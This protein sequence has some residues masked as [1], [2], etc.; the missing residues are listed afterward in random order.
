MAGAG[1]TFSESWHRITDQKLSLRSTVEVRKQ[2]FRGERWYVLHDPFNNSFFRLRPEAHEFV[3]RLRPDRTVGDVWEE[4]LQRNPDSAP[5]QEHVI[6]LLAQ[7]YFANLLHYENPADSAKLFERYRERKQRELKS[8][9]LSIMFIRLPL[10]DPENLLKKIMPVIRSIVS[11]AGAVLWLITVLM[12]GKVFV[13]HF[14]EAAVQAQAILAPD[15]LIFL[16]VSLVLIKTLH[17][18]GHAFVCK[19]FGGEVHTMGIMLMVFTPLPYMDAT[20][21]WSFRSRRERILVSSAGMIFEILAA[22]IAAFI[23]V[24]TGPGMIH[25]LAYNMMF[26]AS[27]S[28]VLFNINPLLRFDGYYILSDL[29]DIPNLHSRSRMHLRHLAEYYLFGC[30]DS[31]SPAQTGREASW[32]TAFGV[33]SGIYR[34]VIFTAIILFVADRFLMAGLIMALICIISWGVAPFIRFAIYLSS[35]PRLSRTRARAASVSFGAL[36]V[37]LFFLSVVPFPNR[38]RAPGILEAES[39]VRVVNDAPGFVQSVLVSSGTDVKSGTPLIALSDHELEL[40]IVAAQAQFKETL[41]LQMRARDREQSEIDPILSR[42][43]TLEKKLEKLD[44]QRRSLLVRARQTGTWVSPRSS[45]MKGT[46]LARGTEIGMIVNYGEVRFTAVV[47]QDD[48]SNLFAGDIASAEVR[49]HGQGNTSLGVSSYEFIPFQFEKLPS[50]ALGWGAGGEIPV[51]IT[52]EKGLET[53]EPFFEVFALL[54][55]HPGI[56]FHHGRS[57]Q[58]RFYLNSEP[59]IQQ[60]L[61][62]FRQVLQKRYQI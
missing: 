1:K 8:K 4:C 32:L 56:P 16:Y 58:I 35:S 42:L 2:V 30:K 28:T 15:N 27:V 41:A 48:A 60:W 17:E 14:D 25:S 10:F 23:W 7:L 21:S 5:G 51:S 61:R 62:K 52:D 44:K 40:E 9:L 37:I 46:W 18:F 24:A 57:G 36:A 29:L 59:L 47:T 33:L 43:E 53:A 45:E 50:A 11:P 6:Q 26:I 12:A 34:V 55:R 49:L 22:S 38:F 3:I 39:H 13:D 19:R 54:N 31:S 20:S